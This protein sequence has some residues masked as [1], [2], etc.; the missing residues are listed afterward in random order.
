[1]SDSDEEQHAARRTP[2]RRAAAAVSYKEV[3]DNASFAASSSEDNE[4][5]T[6][7]REEEDEDEDAMS[8]DSEEEED[9]K[10]AAAAK[11]K[12]RKKRKTRSAPAPAASR[13]KKR[14]KRV[15]TEQHDEDDEDDGDGDDNSVC[16]HCQKKFATPAGCLYHVQHF[17]CQPDKQQRAKKRKPRSKT[18]Q[19][20]QQFPRLRGKLADR[21]CPTCRRVFTSKLGKNYHVGT[22]C[23]PTLFAFVVRQWNGWIDGVFLVFARSFPHTHNHTVRFS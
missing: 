2:R 8:L 23:S 16:P 7:K 12:T 18:G 4:S 15:K 9:S 3:D 21:T 17:V 22:Y 13:K 20:D 11:K 5:I 1:M 19:G 14:S 6:M 10:P